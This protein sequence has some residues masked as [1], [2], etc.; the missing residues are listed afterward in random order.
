MSLFNTHRK[1]IFFFA[2]FILICAVIFFNARFISQE[3]PEFL[4]GEEFF[5]AAAFDIVIPKHP[6][7]QASAADSII[8]DRDQDAA[9]KRDELIAKKGDF[10][11]M[12]LKAMSLALFQHGQ[13][14]KIF[15]IRRAGMEGSFFEIPNGLYHIKSK[16]QKHMSMIGDVGI[17]WAMYLSGNYVIHALPSYANGGLN[18]QDYYAGGIRLAVEDAK[19]L[20]ISASTTMPVL[21]TG[22]EGKKPA[23]ARYFEKVSLATGKP[24]ALQGIQGLSASSAIAADMETGEILFEKQID[25]ARPIASVTKL[26]TALVALEK[27]DSTKYLTVDE[28]AFNTSGDSGKLRLGDTFQ[29]KDFL[30]PLLLASSNDAAVVYTQAI[31]GFIDLMNEKAR[32]LGLTHTFYKDSSGIAPENV[33]SARDLFTLLSYL[34]AHQQQLL[35]I[36]TLPYFA[37]AADNK[38]HSWR[39]LTWPD[40]NGIFLGGKFGFTQQARQ[41]L[42][43]VFGVPM[44]EHGSRRMGIILLGSNDRRHDAMRIIDHLRKNFAYGSILIEKKKIGPSLPMHVGTNTFKPFHGLES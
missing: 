13:Q 44:S 19:E 15:P 30:Y 14:Q 29:A 17:W 16:E 43:A 26:M 18:G 24:T 37:F 9:T 12:D 8:Y 22:Q 39:N 35:A 42:A 32:A 36:S 20:F 6:L 2:R 34:D 25:A 3:L 41:T 40:N 27:I 38:L 28:T 4:A 10:I 33:S 11:F 5:N 7:I 1:Q 21:V 23:P 31:N